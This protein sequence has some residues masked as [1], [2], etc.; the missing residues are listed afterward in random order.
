MLHSRAIPNTDARVFCSFHDDNIFPYENAHGRNSLQIRQKLLSN[1]QIGRGDVR[2]RAISSDLMSSIMRNQT[3]HASPQVRPGV[4]ESSAGLWTPGCRRQGH[5]GRYALRRHLSVY[6]RVWRYTHL[7]RHIKVCAWWVSRW[8]VRLEVA[9][10]MGR[11]TTVSCLVMV[12]FSQRQ[13][14]AN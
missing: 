13:V 14:R 1:R 11:V 6:T 4:R 2:K 12:C 10:D 9:Q 5:D 8:P 7:N 3:R